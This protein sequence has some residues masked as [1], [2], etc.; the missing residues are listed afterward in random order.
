LEPNWTPS[1]IVKSG[2]ERIGTTVTLTYT[3]PGDAGLLCLFGWSLGTSPGISL[4]GGRV[5]PLNADFLLEAAMNGNP[6][7]TPTWALLDGNHQAQSFLH[8]PNAPFVM[9]FTTWI[10]GITSDPSYS[11]M[12][13]KWSQPLSVQP[14]P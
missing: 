5:L 10:A 1:T 9:G 7:L 6:F 13:K 11:R 4:G 12:V 14:L 3:S 8:I 2:S